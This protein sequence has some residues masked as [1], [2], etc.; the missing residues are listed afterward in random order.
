MSNLQHPESPSEDIELENSPQMNTHTS[1]I[2]IT[3]S[4]IPID[5][6]DT[7]QA[8]EAE[9]ETEE[10][11][12]S[13]TRDRLIPTELRER[14]TR[15]LGTLGRRFNIL[16]KIFGRKNPNQQPQHPRGESYDGVFRNLAAKPESNETRNAE[17]TDDTPP[18]YDEAAADMVPSYYGMDLSTSDM[19]MDEICIEGLPVG[20]IANLLWNII[21]STSFQFIGF[22][23]TYILHTCLLYTSRCV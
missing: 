20:N 15:Q 12:G 9:A 22:L 8:N 2:N 11:T 1:E 16:D 6:R 23:I 19:Y 21:V 7:E 13:S 18:T 14:T 3:Q 4:D 10:Q 17:G 5:P